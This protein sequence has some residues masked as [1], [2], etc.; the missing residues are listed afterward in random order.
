MKEA[1]VTLFGEKSPG[2]VFYKLDKAIRV[3]RQYAHEQLAA[4]GLHITVDQWLVLK[5]LHEN[6]GRSQHDIA[7]AAFKDHASFTRIVELLV[8]KDY[9]V[10]DMHPGDRRR[11][12]L[13]ITKKGLKTLQDMQPVIDQNRK[14]ALKGLDRA[15]IVQLQEMLDRIIENCK[16]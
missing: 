4:K 15:A 13:C 5:A 6:P 10:R 16:V 9:L 3:Y 2:N 8:Q 7:G 11:F 14:T 1:P 12:L